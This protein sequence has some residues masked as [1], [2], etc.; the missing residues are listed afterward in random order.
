MDGGRT[1]MAAIGSIRI[2]AG[3]GNL[4]IHGDGLRFT[5]AVGKCITDAAGSGFLTQPGRPRGWF[6]AHLEITVGGLP[7]RP[8]RRLMLDSAGNSMAC[9]L[10]LILI[11]GSDPIASPSSPSTISLTTIS[12]TGDWPQRMSHE[13]IATRQSSTIL[14]RITG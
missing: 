5:M 14:Q 8:A 7:C 1:V 2:V 12:A 9:E 10:E 3:T 6:G 4:S 11:S 13:F